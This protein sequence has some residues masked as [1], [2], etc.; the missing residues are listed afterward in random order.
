MEE[1]YKIPIDFEKFLYVGQLLQAEA[2]KLAIEAHRADMPYCMG[3]LYWQINDCWPVASW[4]GIDYYGKWKALHYAAREAFKPTVLVCSED[5]DLLKIKAISDLKESGNLKLEIRLLDFSGR[6]L[7]KSEKE[8]EIPSQEIEFP[9]KEILGKTDPAS[10]VLVSKLKNVDET[11]DTDL[12]YFVRPKNLNLTDPGIKAEIAEKG[13]LIEVTLKAT[14]L[15]K[16]VFLYAE[17]ID[18]QFS[19]NFFDILPGQQISVTIPKSNIPSDF[20]STLKILH[21]YL[22]DNDD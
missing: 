5:G 17:G 1:D 8:F 13:D 18:G 19:D 16:N 4:S 20:K 9:K 7:W 6:V 3:S 22:T 15:A 12:H 11:V 2:I 14:N 10:V 21:L